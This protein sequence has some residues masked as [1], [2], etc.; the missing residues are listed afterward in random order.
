MSGENQNSRL[1]KILWS[2]MLLLTKETLTKLTVAYFFENGFN[3][4]YRS[5]VQNYEEIVDCW[6]CLKNQISTPLLE[7][8]CGNIWFKRKCQLKFLMIQ[9][10]L[11]SERFARGFSLE[12]IENLQGCLQLLEVTIEKVIKV[13]KNS[14]LKIY[15]HDVFILF[16]LIFSDLRKELCQTS[17]LK[18]LW[19]PA[20]LETRN[21][22]NNE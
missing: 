8:G 6:F 13:F 16:F 2:H 11:L 22:K 1:S 3:Y 18:K 14:C 19:E 21:L 20:G 17:I 12:N 7:E 9:V 4:E 10:K 5:I 15:K